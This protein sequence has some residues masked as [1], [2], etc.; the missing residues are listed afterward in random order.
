MLYKHERVQVEFTQLSVDRD[1][2][3]VMVKVLGAKAGTERGRTHHL[4]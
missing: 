3:H 2:A 1:G 4:V